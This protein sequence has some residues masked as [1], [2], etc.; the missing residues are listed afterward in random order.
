MSGQAANSTNFEV[1]NSSGTLTDISAYCTEVSF[2]QE[3]GLEDSA[4]FGDSFREST[5]TLKGGSFSVSGL[6]DA[7]L[8]AVLGADPAAGATRSFQYGPVGDT[9]GNVKY[10]GECHLENYEV[11][12]SVDGLVSFTATFR[13]SGTITRG[14]Y[15]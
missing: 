13:A 3:K 2:P 14:T 10:T 1:D 4:T 6:W 11:S 5:I 7:T 12:G 9:S 15:A 8:D